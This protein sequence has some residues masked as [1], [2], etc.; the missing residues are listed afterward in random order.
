[1]ENKVDINLA[2]N[3][4]GDTSVSIAI[5]KEGILTDVWI[6]PN[7]LLNMLEFELNIGFGE[8]D[9]NQQERL[10]AFCKGVIELE[11][12]WQARRL[13]SACPKY[14]ECKEDCGPYLRVLKQ[15]AD[16]ID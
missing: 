1:M 16:N 8:F 6:N 15:G 5:D 4:M 2:H 9:I 13:C 10:I 11:P 7:D 12:I 14:L 3:D